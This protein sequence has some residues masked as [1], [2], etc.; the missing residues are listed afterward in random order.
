VHDLYTS[1]LDAFQLHYENTVNFHNKQYEL[2][3]DPSK[4]FIKHAIDKAAEY[5]GYA[6]VKELLIS[7]V[8]SS[9]DVFIVLPTGKQD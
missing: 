7:E 5:L 1:Q 6:T 8:L 2:V 4:D 3:L 9:S